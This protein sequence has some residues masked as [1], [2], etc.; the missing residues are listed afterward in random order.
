MAGVL[1][2]EVGPMFD[3]SDVQQL[4]GNR[5]RV[6]LRFFS[7]APLFRYF[8]RKKTAS[9]LQEQEGTLSQDNTKKPEH[10]DYRSV[11]RDW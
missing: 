5:L 7:E 1:T 2:L 8:S 10:E 3:A 11:M 6:V 9:A 4:P